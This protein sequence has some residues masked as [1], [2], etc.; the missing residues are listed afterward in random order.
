MNAKNLPLKFAFFVVLP[1]LVCLYSI[2]RSGLNVGIDLAGGHSMVFEIRTKEAEMQG[3]EA[4]KGELRG[5]LDRAADEAERSRLTDAIK[6][7]DSE[8]SRLKAERAYARDLPER[9]IAVFKKRVD[10]T[11]LRNIQWRPIGGNRIEVRMPASSAES[12]QAGRRYQE[13]MENLEKGNLQRS[14]IRKVLEA[15]ADRREAVIEAVARGDK[16]MADRLRDFAAANDHAKAAAEKL[17]ELQ[18]KLQDLPADAP[19]EKRKQL[20]EAVGKAKDDGRNARGAWRRL[21]RGL[22]E[23]NISR[24][25]MEV[26][27]RGYI[28]PREQRVIKDE[29][30]KRTRR[31]AFARG[32][33]E[34]RKA[35][36]ARLAEIDAVVE[37]YKAWANIRQHLE[38]PAD[39]KRLIRKAGVLEFRITPSIYMGDRSIRPTDKEM[40]Y[41]RGALTRDGP[42]A[43]RKQ[44]GKYAWFPLHDESGFDDFI[45]ADHAGKT[46]ILLCNEPDKIM[47]QETGR[48]AWRLRRAYPERDKNNRPAVGF[49]FNE[50][51]ARLFNDLTGRHIGRPMA[52]LLDD[53]VYSS[54][55]IQTA[56]S[57][58]GIITGMFTREEVSDLA[59]TLEAGSLPGRLNPQPVAESTFGPAIGQI[60]KER[61]IR[62]AYWG[63]IAVAVSVLAYYL[64]AGGIADVALVL[65]IILVLGAMSLLD[66]V[67]TLPGI[68]GVILTIGIAVDANVL[69]F[70]RLREEQARSQ[71]VRM[72][73]KNAYERAFSAIFD[74]N[75]TTLLTCL[76]LGWVGTQEIRG[77]AITLGLGIVF[78]L[79]TALVVTRWVFQALLDTRILT[80]PVSMLHIIGTPRINWMSKRYFFWCISA[81]LMGLGIAS[82]VVQGGDV[83]GIEFS[84][85]TKA[86]ITLR[87]DALMDG[88]LPNDALISDRFKAKALE[89]DYEKLRATATVETVVG[90]DAAGKFLDKYDADGDERVTEGEWKARAGNEAYFAKLAGDDKSITRLELKDRLPALS[91]QITTTETVLDKVRNTIRA[92]FGPQLE[93]R[94]RLA[95]QVVRGGRSQPIGAAIAADG[96]TLITSD[97]AQKAEAAYQGDLEDFVG[98]VMYV[99]RDVTP[100]ISLDELKQR[101]AGMRNQPDFDFVRI[102]ETDVLGVGEPKDGKYTSFLVLAAPADPDASRT[103]RTWNDFTKSAYQWVVDQPLTREEAIVVNNF[104]AAIAA[105]ATGLAVVAILLSCA[106]IVIY[107][108]VRFGSAQ[109]GLAA[110]ICLVHDVII[111]VGLVAVSGWLHDKFLG[112]LLGIESFKIDLAMIAAL[113]TVIGYSV[114]DTIV[115]FDRIR[116][117]RGKLTTISPQVLNASINQTLS[118]TLL[119]SGTTFMVVFIMYVWGGPGIH[120]FN[121]AL[122]AGIIFG[123]YSSVAVASPLLLGFKQALVVKTAA[124]RPAADRNTAPKAQ[125]LGPGPK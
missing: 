64:L 118:R 3:L 48:I 77:F 94:T 24:G 76:I 37:A 78:S 1:A 31:E 115:V 98:G 92:A 34:I 15:P 107:L 16:P 32:M 123:T 45:L 44:G 10:P 8:L 75:V 65:N 14:E 51:G 100:A 95:F 80:K 102:N 52:I 121:Y 63:L 122:L 17:K 50:A 35:H 114:N 12:Q 26:I 58:K 43:V 110:V 33:E 22:Q 68:A 36:A 82:L 7:I 70:E 113:L 111:V 112:R 101:I 55:S 2:Y 109:W 108:W 105:E 49:E 81:V 69:I 11:G 25:Q 97:L 42:E 57:K 93:K 59:R 27:L 5:R 38:D 6:A 84:A 29:Q 66:A 67:F 90:P 9:M 13:A 54:P 53:E 47:L 71:S 124:G 30:E 119:T 39:L 91:Y 116:E 62:A 89:L 96:N 4:R 83:L 79:F 46:Y 18:G 19:K 88:E 106:A 86:T 74:A 21:R 56:I 23:G 72:A 60:N 61:G 104:D 117:N 99:V 41:Y 73:L 85:G 40:D 28:S 87:G 103:T 120:A 20:A 125:G